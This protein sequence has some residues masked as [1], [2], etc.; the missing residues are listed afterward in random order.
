V[1]GGAALFFLSWAQPPTFRTGH[2]IMGSCFGGLH[3]AY[4]VYLRFTEKPLPPA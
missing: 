2:L 1:L 4:G 3:L